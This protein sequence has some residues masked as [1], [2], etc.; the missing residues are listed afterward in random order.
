VPQKMF[1]LFI[2]FPPLEIDFQLCR[3]VIT[4]HLCNIQQKK[5]ISVQFE[6]AFTG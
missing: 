6:I 3:S 2:D 4:F 1:Y 5:K